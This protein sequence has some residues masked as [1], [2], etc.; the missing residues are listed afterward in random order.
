MMSLVKSSQRERCFTLI[1]LLVVIAIIAILA[2][3]LLPALNNAR[4]K[5]RSVFCVSNL[6]QFSLIANMYADDNKD[7]YM[8]QSPVWVDAFKG[9]EKSL[10]CPSNPY[11]TV[12]KYR[13][14]YP[15]TYGYNSI[16]TRV[17]T[18][19]PKI[20]PRSFFKKP[21]LLF[22][23]ADANTNP[24]LTGTLSSD[25]LCFPNTIM[26]HCN[27]VAGGSTVLNDYAL[28]YNN[29][30]TLFGLVHNKGVNM[31]FAD[32]HSAHYNRP[33]EGRLLWGSTYSWD[34]WK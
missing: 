10:L 9:A 5:A 30:S 12:K 2:A 6:K 26:A 32:G 11:R 21:N 15:T 23:A 31:A 17:D 19:N 27:L 8:Y 22:L 18:Y 28:N 34:F 20:S 4:E 16:F 1:E 14:N 7:Y 29:V 24:N 33:R 3:L 13:E 25:T